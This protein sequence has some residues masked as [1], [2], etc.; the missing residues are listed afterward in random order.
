MGCGVG[1]IGLWLQTS[2]IMTNT[3]QG[4]A[5]PGL[6]RMGWLMAGRPS[7]S[8]PTLAIHPR[9]LYGLGEAHIILLIC[10][11]GLGWAMAVLASAMPGL[12]ASSSVG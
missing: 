3:D 1:A 8:S 11:Y 7:W 12:G 10:R 6:P 5:W 4:R 2:A 9:A